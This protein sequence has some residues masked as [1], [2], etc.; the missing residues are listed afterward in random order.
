V[1]GT[2]LAGLARRRTGRLVA[3][4]IGVLVAVALLAAI[5][6]FLGASRATMTARAISRVAVDWQVQVAQ[7]A[8]QAAVEAA[9]AARP[10]TGATQR[11]EFATVPALTATTPAPG[12]GT[13]V[14]TT[15]SARVLGLPDGYRATFP[16]QLRTLVGADTGVLVAQQTAA[17]LHVTVGDTVVVARPGLPDAAVRVDGV[18]ELPQA[19]TLFQTVGAPPGAQPTAPPDNVVLLP[20]IPWHDLFDPLAVERPDLLSTQVHVDRTATLPADP[21]AAYTAE[22]GAARNTEAQLAG[23]GIVGDNLAA[24]LDAARQ[25]ASYAQV[26]FLFLGLPGSALAGL[27]TAAVAGAGA[28]RRAREQALL[29]TRGATHRQ[30]LALAAGE[31]LLVGLAGGLAG[32]G[33][34]ALL[35]RLLFG[36][37]AFGATAR[38]AAAWAGLAGI[39]GLVV[40]VATVV[41]PAERAWREGRVVAAGS[42]LPPARRPQWARWGLDL[43]ALAVAVLI[44]WT[45]SRVGYT[46]VLAPEG[47][48][49]I[50]VDYWAFL[51]PALL[52]VGGG[53]LVW[54]L[55]DLLLRR[56][57]RAL[58]AGLRPLA[59]TLAPTVAAGL[60]RSRVLVTRGAVVLALAVAFAVSTATFDATYEQ[61][62]LVD[63]RL[64]N[65]A[66]VTV[67][68]P[69]GADVPP[70]A[71]QQFATVPGVRHVEP[72][73][74]RFGYV[75]TDLQDLYGV[76]PTTIVSGASLQDSWFTG[77]TAQGL[78]NTLAATPDGVL[79]SAETVTDYQLHP[80]DALVLRVQSSA[81][82]TPVAATFHFVGVVNEFPT[83]PRDSFLVADADY[84]ASVTGD[85][86]V[87]Y[88]LLDTGGRNPDPVAQ[89]VA[90]V[91]G[92]GATVSPLS[93]AVATI[94]SS[95]TAV[96]LHGLSLL[97]LGFSFVLG[98]AAGGLV[99]ALGMTERRRTFAIVR[100]LGAT[101]RQTAAFVVGES[102]L[103]TVTGLLLGGLLGA[104]LARV[105]VSVLSGV[106][107]PPPSS[108]AVPVG[109][110]AGLAVA[111]IGSA[112][113]ASALVVRWASRA[114]IAA[115]RES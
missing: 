77:G 72:V 97:E 31:A 12:G 79:V 107:D 45:T 59:G 21:A 81:Q 75:G 90:A 33:V 43:I 74:H 49:T 34:A 25:D 92:A 95:L 80:G 14:Q 46:L 89:Q 100:A 109:F 13:S 60:G 44:V 16:G 101:R 1:I 113:V 108:L 65:G 29:R 2:W 62:A 106:F 87:G 86:S 64:T 69:P 73:L 9:V 41:L 27:L 26:L 28:H 55:T 110:L 56:G 48:A 93:T 94:G 53:L 54:R 39:V 8:D 6:S 61:Q 104:G 96:D 111:I 76:Q 88:F 42:V 71:A 78:M 38:A 3:A 66:D 40:A 10:G 52:W 112:A 32:V 91:A 20:A 50:S 63:A 36:S 35:G 7:G 11:M 19:D 30:A 5:G 99:L 67:A 15:G 84:L 70:S 4:A 58:T 85:P 103:V 83:A 17:N 18:V 47:V 22:T 115:L 57:R 82:G 114:P 102:V 68:E 105:L 24:T 23:A 51:G 98:S 37:A